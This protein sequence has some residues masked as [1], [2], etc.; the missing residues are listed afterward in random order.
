MK[1]AYN[2]TWVANSYNQDVMN[3]WHAQKLLTDEQQTDA[4]RAFPVG[5][6]QSNA[7]VKIG[8]FLF[9]SIASSSSLGVISLLL[10]SMVGDSLYGY[11]TVSLI[12]GG[13]FLY[14]LEFFI[15]K[16]KFYRSGVDNALLYAA[17]G[18]IFGAFLGFSELALPAWGYCLLILVVLIPALLRYADPLV[19]IA[20]Y[21]IFVA[22]CFLVITK[23]PTGKIIIPFVIMLISAVSYWLMQYWQ[24]IDKGHYYLD[25]QAVISILA[26]ITFYLGG[27]YWIVREGNALLNDLSESVQIVSKTIRQ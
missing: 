27:N 7:F 3:D 4:R 5:F 11:A 23:F 20:T 24:R 10:I 25:N 14:I 8:L 13:G 2:E 9:T 26:L 22:F 18:S 12:Y 17:L 6:K 16:E 19:A 1:K 15:K 21:L